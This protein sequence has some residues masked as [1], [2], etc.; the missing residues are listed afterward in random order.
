MN[1]WLGDRRSS[2]EEVEV[3]ALVGLADVAREDGAVAAR[4]LLLRLAPGALPA[5][6]LGGFHLEVQL[7]LVDIEL[8]QI[9]ALHQRERT[10]DEGLRRDV[11]H[12]GAVA[13]TAH[14]SVGNTHHVAYALLQEFLRDRQHAPFGHPGTAERT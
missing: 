4:E 2:L 1:L 5:R 6:Q 10:A 9:A 14:A 7:A 3:A 13:R 11:Q 8:D 12:A